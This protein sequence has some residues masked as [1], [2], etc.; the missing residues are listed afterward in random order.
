MAHHQRKPQR[1][2]IPVLGNDGLSPE[3]EELFQDIRSWLVDKRTS[4][5]ANKWIELSDP[6][7][8]IQGITCVLE[9]VVDCN[10]DIVRLFHSVGGSDVRSVKDDVTRDHVFRVDLRLTPGRSAKM[11][12]SGGGGSF[13]DEP[14]VLITGIALTLLSA[15]FTTPL[16][17]W[18]N[19]ARATRD[20][21]M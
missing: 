7:P 8:T 1:T 15:A 17:T 6:T 9:G 18:L 16:S 12:V 20:V 13:L 11:G 4:L 10:D 21:L 5:K 2:G 19:L 3:Q 14:R